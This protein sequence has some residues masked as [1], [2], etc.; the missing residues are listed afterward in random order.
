MAIARA[1]KRAVDGP[2]STRSDAAAA[3]C[4]RAIAS[5]PSAARYATFASR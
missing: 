3:L 2:M 5:G 4:E 1:M